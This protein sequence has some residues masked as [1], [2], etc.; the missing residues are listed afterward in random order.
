[1]KYAK[2]RVQVDE[3]LHSERAT[4]DVPQNR[5]Q[6]K[7]EFVLVW[8]NIVARLPKP[9]FAPLPPDQIVV[10]PERRMIR[11]TPMKINCD[12]AIGKIKSVGKSGKSLLRSCLFDEIGPHRLSEAFSRFPHRLI[13]DGVVCDDELCQ[14]ISE[15]VSGYECLLGIDAFADPAG[16]DN[17][18]ELVAD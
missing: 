18:V 6:S 2:Y 10:D 15:R 9:K 11:E 1:M 13:T 8:Q 12:L 3:C 7:D 17:L 14:E 16:A 4:F 5:D